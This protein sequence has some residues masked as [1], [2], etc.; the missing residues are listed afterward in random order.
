MKVVVEVLPEA[1]HDLITLLER[2]SPTESDAVAFGYVYLED[3]EQ[4]FVRH[5]GFPPGTR[6][7]RAPDGS[8]WWWRY[9][10]GV[11]VV[12]RAAETSSWFGIVVR[13][14]TIVAFEAAPPSV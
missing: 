4:L 1:R 10:N 11:W 14:I 2:K 6:R 3:L 7:A 5:K 13:R 12:Y 8:V 9:V